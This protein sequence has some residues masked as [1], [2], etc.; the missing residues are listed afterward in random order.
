MGAKMV[1]FR[2][3]YEDKFTRADYALVR[4]FTMPH[5]V[6]WESVPTYSGLSSN[7]LW[8]RA[9]PALRGRIP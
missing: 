1:G 9:A 6:G 5:V 7:L 3:M 4:L 2:D 8:L